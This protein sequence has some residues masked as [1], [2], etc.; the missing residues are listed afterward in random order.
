[1][2]SLWFIRFEVLVR[3]VSSKRLGMRLVEGFS[4]KNSA[5]FNQTPEVIFDFLAHQAP[6][7]DLQFDE[8]F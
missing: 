7:G 8:A 1:M 5:E 2:F 4:L 3:G 6:L